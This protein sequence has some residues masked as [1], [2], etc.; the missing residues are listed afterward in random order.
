MTMRRRPTPLPPTA[1]HPSPVRLQRGAVLYVAMVVLV[2]LALAALALLRSVDVLGLVAANLSFKRSALSATDI[3]TAKA[4]EKYQALAAVPADLLADSAA[5]CYSASILDAD[6]HGVPNPL[7]SMST[8][9]TTY[10]NCQLTT[11]GGSET[12]SFLIDRQCPT[13]GAGVAAM[14][15]SSNNVCAVGSKQAVGTA[16][17]SPPGLF[18]TKP[19]YRITIRTDGPR[20]SASFVQVIFKS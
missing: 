18:T 3:G 7:A 2:A 4:M 16:A 14:S 15:N 12:I 11:N 17:H 20:N 5:N 10:P 13:A 9:A 19:I 6:S 8:F 1:R